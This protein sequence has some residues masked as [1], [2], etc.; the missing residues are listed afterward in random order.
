MNTLNYFIGLN[1]S[2]KNKY[3]FLITLDGLSIINSSELT[4]KDLMLILGIDLLLC[5][6]VIFKENL[7]KRYIY[8]ELEREREFKKDSFNYPFILTIHLHVS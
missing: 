3:N 8:I 1:L 6:V 4:F 7:E 2:D 5:N